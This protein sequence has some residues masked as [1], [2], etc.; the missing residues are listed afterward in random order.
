MALVRISK[1]SVNSAFLAVGR[2]VV[3]Y[4]TLGGRAS[5]QQERSFDADRREASNFALKVEH[6]KRARVFI[7]PAAG[8]VLFR[9]YAQTWLARHL[10]A[11]STWPATGPCSTRMSSRACC[12]SRSVRVPFGI[13]WVS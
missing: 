3:R 12:S 13:L 9:A 5:R 8:D 10:G 1:G 6:D 2:L 11:D 4:R 7:D